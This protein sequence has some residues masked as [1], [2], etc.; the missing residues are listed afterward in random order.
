[1]GIY[2]KA[3][4]C[5]TEELKICSNIIYR[6][7]VSLMIRMRPFN[8]MSYSELQNEY[9]RQLV[10]ARAVAFND[11][12][13]LNT[14]KK[15]RQ[16]RTLKTL[17]LLE[18]SGYMYKGLKDFLFPN[19]KISRENLQLLLVGPKDAPASLGGNGSCDSLRQYFEEMIEIFGILEESPE[20]KVCKEIFRYGALNYKK[21]YQT[22]NTAYWLQRQLRVKVCPYCNRMYTTTLFGENKI[23]PDFDH[24]YPKSKYPYL[25]V[26]L[27]N[28]IPS[29]SMCN[30]KKGNTAEVIHKK[31]KEENISIIY[32]Y[33]ESFDE[34]QR[35]ISF[36]VI[37]SQKEVMMGQ[38]D[39]FT[40][41]LQPKKYSDKLEFNNAGGVLTKTDMKTRFEHKIKSSL[42]D[43]EDVAKRESQFWD[44]A[45]ASIDLLLIEKFYNEHKDEIMS[46]LRNHYQYNQD[47]IELIMKTLLRVKH[48]EATEQQIKISTRDMLYFAFLQHEEWGSSPLNKLKSDILAQLDEIENTYI[49]S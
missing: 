14:T 24:F 21:S 18:Q 11:E 22:E 37:S 48:P 29:C 45:E 39:K 43:K 44:R 6:K 23:R 10:D 38:S 30:T 46:I 25:A 36:R 12:D 13:V 4:D 33:D 27:F 7:K 3:T 5:V 31:V 19:G 40:I 1:M 8:K 49:D 2:L 42:T 41:E 34:P 32:P 15:S 17:K 35:C 47:S 20:N 9:L 26:S 28:L 16:E